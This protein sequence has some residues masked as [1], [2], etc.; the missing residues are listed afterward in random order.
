MTREEALFA[1]RLHVEKGTMLSDESV[2]AVCQHLLASESTR[3]AGSPIMLPIGVAPGLQLNPSLDG[4]TFTIE[5][6][7][8]CSTCNDTHR[9]HHTQLGRDV[10]C[11]ECPMPCGSCRE[12]N[13]VAG[14]YCATTPCNCKCHAA[15]EVWRGE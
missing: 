15:P 11:I 14:A 5:R 1:A 13:A 8:V 12:I 9:R 6:K 3:L 2:K 4:A 7:V 10:P